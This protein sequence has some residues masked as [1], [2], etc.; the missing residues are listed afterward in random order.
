MPCFAQSIL[1]S[2]SYDPINQ[3]HNKEQAQLKICKDYYKHHK[4][5]H[6]MKEINFEYKADSAL[7][8]DLVISRTVYL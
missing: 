2:S 8:E 6:H 1:L 5:F 3:C 7:L 4:S